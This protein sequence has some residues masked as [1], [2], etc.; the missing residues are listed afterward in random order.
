M[1]ERMSKKRPLTKKQRRKRKIILFVV[2]IIVLLILIAVLVVAMKMGKIN[3]QEIKE[4]DI[5]KNEVDKTT[6]EAMEKYTTFALFGLDNRTNGTYDSGNADTIMVV[7]IDNKTKEVKI[8]SVYRDTYMK[9]NDKSFSKIN[10]AYAQGGP[11]EMIQALDQNLDLHITDYV[12]VDWYA[13]AKAVDL[14]GGVKIEVTS[15][16]AK[17]IN[18]YVREAEIHTGLKTHNGRVAQGLN[19]LDGIQALSYARIRAIGSDF[20]RTERQ[21]TVVN[22]MLAKAKTADVGTLLAM[23]DEISEKIS[24][25]MSYGEMASLAKDVMSYSIGETTGFPYYHK[26]QTVGRCGDCLVPADLLNN[27]SKL[28]GFLFQNESYVPSSQLKTISDYVI[29]QTG[30]KYTP[31]TTPTNGN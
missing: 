18:Q 11:K 6:T 13:L 3:R 25:S 9:I 29:R 15:G 28:H 24:T 1:E 4:T 5:R 23:L 27:V 26:G 21:R 2:E 19:N 12:A 30:V 14:L 7:S 8:A 20:Q 17:L 16:E 31:P 22:A 10:A